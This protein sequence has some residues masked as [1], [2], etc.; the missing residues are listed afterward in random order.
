MD[1]HHFP[2]GHADFYSLI[3]EGDYYVDRTNYIRVLEEKGRTMLFLRPRRFGKSLLLSML[4]NYYDVNKADN[5]AQLFGHLAIGKNPTPRHNQYLILQWDFSCVN[6]HGTSDAIQQSLYDHINSSIVACKKLYPHIIPNDMLI[7]PTDALTSFQSLLTAVRTSPYSLYL[8]VDE[9]DNFANEVFMAQQSG[10]TERYQQLVEGE[11]I[12]KTVFKIVK[13]AL[14]GRGLERVFMTGVLPVLANDLTS[15][16]NIVKNI[17][18]EPDLHALCGF[19]EA[20][21]TAMLTQVAAVCQL[22]DTQT[23]EAIMMLRTFYNGYRFSLYEDIRLYN[24]T[25][26]LYFLDY[27]QSHCRYPQNMLDANLATDRQK[28][29][30]V[31]R[32]PHGDYVIMAALEETEPLTVAT[33]SEHFGV[34]HILYG[35]KTDPFMASFLYYLG[36]LTLGDTSPLGERMLTIPNQVTRQL[37]A[38]QIQELLLPPGTHNDVF[39]VVKR[40]YSQGDMGAVCEFIEQTYF[41][42]LDNRDYRG[43]NELTIKMLFVSL[44]FN[45]RYYMLDSEPALQRRYADLLLLVRPDMRQYQLYDLLI[46]CKYLG[47]RDL[48]MAGQDISAMDRSEVSALPAVVR[49]Q[50][51]ARAQVQDYRAVLD[52]THGER[53]KLRCFSVVALG[54]ERLVWE[55]VVGEG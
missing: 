39:Q 18:L 36:V 38:K 40:C 37:Y 17:T 2:Y 29:H 27:L 12:I 54:Y 34:P 5:F 32:I 46:E 35:E 1:K 41:T 25:L 6:P 43:A 51:E 30:Y 11:G 48:G 33:L 20:E 49:L 3:T 19:T 52:S 45:N 14:A 31:S 16:F 22:T 9:Y 55:E 13:S 47:L 42:V 8:L 15:G 50:A 24:P 7:N 28:I 53:L 4:E 21:V 23:E 44:L 26:I 10:S